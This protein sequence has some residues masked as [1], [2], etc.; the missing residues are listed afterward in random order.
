MDASV[1]YR[2]FG[3]KGFVAVDVPSLADVIVR[4]QEL[5][6]LPV[7]TRLDLQSA[8]RKVAGA[9]GLPP[10]DVPAQPGFLRQR[11]AKVGRAGHGLSQGRWANVRSLL[12]RALKLTGVTVLPNRYLAPTRRP[13][14]CWTP[15]IEDRSTRLGLARL[16]HFASAQ[17]V[18]PEAVDDGF[19]AAYRQ[20]LEQG[21]H[22][23]GLG[24]AAGATRSAS[25]T[26][27][28]TRSRAGRQ[29]S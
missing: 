2:S 13:G 11:L 15:R 19:M 7:R 6:D 22:R 25:G 8:V 20:A 12:L 10:G 18:A 27:L 16:M 5:A 23:Q 17:G 4:L 3:V 21:E 24:Q 1:T 14:R 9:L 28:W 29:G 26:A